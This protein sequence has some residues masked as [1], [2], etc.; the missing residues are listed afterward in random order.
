MC[1]QTQ[2]KQ[3]NTPLEQTIKH[4]NRKFAQK[5]STLESDLLKKKKKKVKKNQL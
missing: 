3:A 2:T 1:T 4:K 5:Q